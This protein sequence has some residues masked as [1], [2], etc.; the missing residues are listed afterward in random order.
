MSQA[1]AGSSSSTSTRKKRKAETMTESEE[2]AAVPVA[3]QQEVEV[4]EVEDEDEEM[5]EME[6]ME[7]ADDDDY[8]YTYEDG[9]DG[10]CD[11]D[12]L[13]SGVGGYCSSAAAYRPR[14]RATN[15]VVFTGLDKI[16]CT[17]DMLLKKELTRVQPD[18]EKNAKGE[19]DVVLSWDEETRTLGVVLEYDGFVKANLT[20]T[21]PS[22]Y[23]QEPPV[24]KWLGP[25]YDDTVD[26]VLGAGIFE[27]TKK[28]NWVR[29]VVG[30]WVEVG[31]GLG[32][33]SVYCMHL[34]LPPTSSVQQQLIRTA[35]ASFFS[36]PPTHLPPYSRTTPSPAPPS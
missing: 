35:A 26:F 36:H 17:N 16:G 4:V 30:G 9:D 13:G 1:S 21:F 20:L 5:E 15:Y 23:P 28:E 31:F 19:W 11:D 22:T 34:F 2:T 32:L 29:R 3:M 33:L 27:P 8:E 10:G 18:I 12:D 6:E 24:F 25:R 14:N 7:E